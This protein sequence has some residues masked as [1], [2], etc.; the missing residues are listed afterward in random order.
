MI[1]DFRTTSQAST[2]SLSTEI[3]KIS[4]RVQ[5][6]GAIS[7]EQSATL[8]TSIEMIREILTRVCLSEIP[9]QHEAEPT[10]RETVRVSD[11]HETN[12]QTIRPSNDCLDDALGR[13]SK[14]VK[15]EEQTLFSVEEDSIINDMEQILVYLLKAE[16]HYKHHDIRQGKKRACD[17]SNGGDDEDVQYQHDM[18]RMKR[19]LNASDLI[20]LKKKGT[21]SAL[22]TLL[23]NTDVTGGKRQS[24]VS[25]RLYFKTMCH[26]RSSSSGTFTIKARHGTNA[27][28][29]SHNVV[30]NSS[31]D[32]E[33]QSFDVS[34]IYVPKTPQK[35]HI[36]FALS[37]RTLLEGCS[38]KTPILSVSALLPDDS[39]VFQ[40]IK[41]GEL[42][43]LMKM[44]SLREV[45]LSDRDTKGRCLLNVSS[46]SNIVIW[47]GSKSLTTT[48]RNSI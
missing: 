23:F 18:K 36:A 46:G 33:L 4:D 25:N 16:D 44:L 7:T 2:Q 20:A 12:E 22:Y 34:V 45:S 31:V 19:I 9:Q 10:T 48:A 8:A 14:L 41:N 27:N 13:L 40:V 42:D 15:E 47:K 28:A 43:Q 35:A 6:I 26:V 38:L 24:I 39:K 30:T 11:D 1:G 17:E 5:N 32:E 37:Q 21:H 3:Q 29:T